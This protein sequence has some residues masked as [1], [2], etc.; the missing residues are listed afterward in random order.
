MDSGFE[1][2]SLYKI[3]SEEVSE[4]ESKQWPKNPNDPSERLNRIEDALKDICRKKSVNLEIVP[5][6]RDSNRNI[7]F[8][9]RYGR[10]VASCSFDA[11]ILLILDWS[12]NEIATMIFDKAWS[13]AGS[14]GIF[15]NLRR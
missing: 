13:K 8:I 4:I 7:L 5:N 12:A 14:P 6:R 15:K 11:S 1:L 3:A 9:F 10:L 2:D